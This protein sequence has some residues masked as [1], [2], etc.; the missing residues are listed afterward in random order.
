MND[1]FEKRIR[2]A[3]IAGWWVV[4]IALAFIFLQL[5]LMHARPPCVLLM[6]GPNLDW[7]FV[8]MVWFWAIAA[9]KFVLLLI[10][11]IVLWLTLWA[12]QLRKQAKGP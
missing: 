6:W 7:P 12:R 8:Q 3:A 5:A 1:V 11:L 2:A 10:V 9:L 4:L